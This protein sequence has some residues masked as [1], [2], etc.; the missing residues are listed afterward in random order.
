MPAGGEP[1]MQWI[2]GEE[3]EDGMVCGFTGEV[4]GEEERLK[5]ICFSA[6]KEAEGLSLGEQRGWEGLQIA[7]LVFWKAWP[8]VE[9]GASVW[10]KG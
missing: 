7:H 2:A 6:R 1:G 8:V 10:V 5:L 9:Q 4:G 3:G